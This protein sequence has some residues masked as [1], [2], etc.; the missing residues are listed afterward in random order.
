MCRL[1]DRLCNTVGAVTAASGEHTN[2]GA[3]TWAV[4][5]YI[6]HRVSFHGGPHNYCKEQ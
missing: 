5:L 1:T 6:T 2:H 3:A 4:R